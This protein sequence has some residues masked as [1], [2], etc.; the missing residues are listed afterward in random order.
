MTDFKLQR[1]KHKE[2]TK[3]SKMQ[4]MLFKIWDP[5][6]LQLAIYTV[7]D[8]ESESEVKNPKFLKPGEGKKTLNKILAGKSQQEEVCG[9]F[10]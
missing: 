4:I 3:L 9:K 10:S 8:E 1:G 5:R 6:P 2:K 7:S